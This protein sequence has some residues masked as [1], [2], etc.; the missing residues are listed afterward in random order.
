MERR[1]TTRCGDCRYT[2]T[3]L[4]D[5]TATTAGVSRERWPCLCSSCQRVVSVLNNC[6]TLVCGCGSTDMEIYG[7]AS[8]RRGSGRLF[9][10]EDRAIEDEGYVCPRCGAIALLLTPEMIASN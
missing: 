8:P 6:E 10:S 3:E 1:A 2:E 7:A 4:V 5:G 9:F